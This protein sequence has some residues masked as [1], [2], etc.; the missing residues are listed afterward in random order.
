V[1]PGLAYAQQLLPQTNRR[2]DSRE[3]RF[4]CCII[5][6][7]RD[8]QAAPIQ[9]AEVADLP[10]RGCEALCSELREIADRSRE[11]AAR[12]EDH[13]THWTFSRNRRE[14]R[15]VGRHVL[16]HQCHGTW[17][18]ST[19]C[20]RRRV[21]ACPQ[22]LE[23]QAP[24][25]EQAPIAAER[26]EPLL[27]AEQL[28][29]SFSGRNYWGIATMISEEYLDRAQGVELRTTERQ[30]GSPRKLWTPRVAGCLATYRRISSPVEQ[31]DESG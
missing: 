19:V 13:E 16:Q 12:A 31:H 4:P 8:F 25:G 3:P 2:P 21:Q 20:E 7:N 27:I 28:K 29:R 9:I 23:R 26:V 18:H 5:R 10:D 6:C 30:A 11:V 15:V 14:R 17:T 22:H 1:R 24:R